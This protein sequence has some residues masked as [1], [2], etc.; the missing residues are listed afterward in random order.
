MPAEFESGVFTEGKAAWHGLGVVLPADVLDAQE[1]LTYS[2]LAG[3][4]L[5]KKPLFVGNPEDGY[6]QVPDKWAVQRAT[7]GRVLGVV[8][9]QYRIVHNEEAFE[10]AN[11]LVGGDGF[12]FKAAGSLYG[13]R[14][15]W[16][17]LKTPFDLDL[18]DSKVEQY[19]LLWN[20][21]DGGGPLMAQLTNIRV[22]CANT[23]AMAYQ[24]A[25]TKFGIQHRSGAAGK[26]AE[27]QRV[28][29]LARGAAER[30]QEIAERMLGEQISDRAWRHLLDSLVPVP[31]EGSK[32]ARTKA[33]QRQGVIDWN[34]R[35]HETQQ[36]IVGTKWGAYNAFALWDDHLAP[37][38]ATHFGSADESRMLRVL[39]DD[40]LASKAFA[41]LAATK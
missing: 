5:A 29:G 3:W 16:V 2:G 11:A 7:D 14:R 9:N 24:Q 26:L 32:A 18:P 19:L 1:A 23:L 12:H 17:L 35:S 38:A 22:V 4:G 41:K 30:Q 8:G 20:R 27:A 36:G 28:L 21:H 31:E 25:K 40:S 33:L 37:V 15:V 39:G 13:G 6:Q 34:Y 10:W